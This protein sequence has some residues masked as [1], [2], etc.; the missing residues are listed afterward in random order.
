MDIDKELVALIRSHFDAQWMDDIRVECIVEDGRNFITHTDRTYDIISIE[1]GQIFRPGCA[2]FYTGDFYRSAGHRLKPGGL[3][4]QFVPLVFL[5]KQEFLSVI[6]TFIEVFPNST[7]WYNRNEF[8]LIGALNTQP[9]LTEKRLALL[10]NNKQVHQDLAYYYWGGPHNALH[11][12]EVFSAG[13]LYGPKSLKRLTESALVYYDDIPALEYSSAEI[14]KHAEKN[15][16]DILHMIQQTVDNPGIIFAQRIPGTIIKAIEH[17]RKYNLRNITAMAFF[18]RYLEEKNKAPLLQAFEQNPYNYDIS[19]HLGQL[20][21]QEE[22]A[23][24]SENYFRQTLVVYPEHANAQYNLGLMQLKQGSAD[25]ALLH[26]Y[27]TIRL[28]PD[29]AQAYN[30]IGVILAQHGEYEKAI[31]HFSHAIKNNPDNKSALKNQEK[32]RQK[33]QMMLEK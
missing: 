10:E 13:F 31:E 18:R 7:L 22:N 27:E 8:L 21:A 15:P 4:C 5:D 28:V 30:T 3:I 19:F 32:A 17:I 16:A 1:I 25:S 26:F 33:L 9:V 29:H 2:S 11:K 23:V 24:E 6:R 14:R 20:F 12:P